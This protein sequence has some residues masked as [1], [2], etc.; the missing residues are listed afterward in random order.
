MRT[1]D[2]DIEKPQQSVGQR[3]SRET[4]GV[5]QSK[6]EVKV[7]IVMAHW[8]VVCVCVS[9]CVC[10]VVSNSLPLY[11]LQPTR[12]LCPWDFPG[13]KTVVGWHFLLQEIFPTLGWNPCLLYLLQWKWIFLPLSHWGSPSGVQL[14][15]NLGQSALVSLMKQHRLGGFKCQIFT[16]HYSRC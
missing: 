8:D 3:D 9:V 10:S 14:H 16:S 7:S 11:G 1:E 2:M 13:K 4:R 12:V 5:R 15:P 6:S